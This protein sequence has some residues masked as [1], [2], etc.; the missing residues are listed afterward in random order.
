MRVLENTH[1]SQ[2]LRVTGQLSVS[3]APVLSTLMFGSCEGVDEETD[4]DSNDPHDREHHL[5]C[6]ILV[7]QEVFFP[8]PFIL[9][10]FYFP[11]VWNCYWKMTVFNSHV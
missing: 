9:G 3:P 5:E 2:H 8:V 10:V 7:L 1:A 11:F 6:I 4:N